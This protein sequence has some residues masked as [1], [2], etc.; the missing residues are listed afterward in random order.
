VAERTVTVKHVPRALGRV[1]RLLGAVTIGYVV[2]GVC[3][4]TS[5]SAAVSVSSNWAGY[6]VVPSASAHSAFSSISGSW[7]VPAATCGPAGDTY[8]AA[9][10]GLGGFQER[11]QAL[12][13]IGTEADCGGS[14]SAVYSAW[15]ELVPAAPVTLSLKVHAGDAIA[16]SVTVKGHGVTLRIRDLSTGKIFTRT[17]R[18]SKVDSSSA[19]WIVEAPSVCVT[20][21]ICRTLTLTDFGSVAFSDLSATAGEHAG[22]VEDPLWSATGLGLH[23]V[24]DFPRDTRASTASTSVTAVPSALSDGGSAFVVSW[25]EQAIQAEQAA[26]PTLP[27]FNGGPP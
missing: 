19:E 11:S 21:S 1:G 20:A 2:L 26:P 6:A 8:S 10:V 25:S 27:G 24:Q 3:V 17:R 4:S 7:T 13:Q 5:A 16:A 9:W 18:A 22:P 15:Y 12:E 23:E 14:A